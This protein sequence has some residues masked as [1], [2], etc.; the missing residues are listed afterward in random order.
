MYWK[1]RSAMASCC[2]GKYRR[3]VARSLWFVC[4]TACVSSLLVVFL[5]VQCLE[6]HREGES[7]AE[8]MTRGSSSGRPPRRVGSR[9]ARLDLDGVLK[10]NRLLRRIVRQLRVAL[11]PAKAAAT[12]DDNAHRSRMLRGEADD[13]V[14]L[15]QERSLKFVAHAERKSPRN[16]VA[17]SRDLALNCEDVARIRIG[18]EIG[19][20]YTKVTQHGIY[21][22]SEVAVK[23]AG[24]DSTDVQRCVRD[25]RA[26]MAE[27]CLL[28]S[29]YKIMKELLLYQQLHHPNIVKVSNIVYIYDILV[30]LCRNIY[31][32][33]LR[34]C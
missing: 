17:A 21:K 8:E 13:G 32:I 12:A 29:R 10:E 23:S 9:E 4:C 22:G 11:G 1:W 34:Q 31:L 7:I 14:R 30:Y 27:D 3:S 16:S 2:R 33:L 24:L 20:G 5:S 15:W 6:D 18:R 26:K 25:G 19:R 28:F